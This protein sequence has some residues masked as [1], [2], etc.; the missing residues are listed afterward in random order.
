MY[1][2]FNLPSRRPGNPHRIWIFDKFCKIGLLISHSPGQKVFQIPHRRYI[3][4]D[5]KSI[6]I[7]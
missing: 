5:Q 7:I 6:L 1:K 3:L 2:H 4:G